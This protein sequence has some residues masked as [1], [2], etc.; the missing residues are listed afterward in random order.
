MLIIR[1][2]YFVDALTEDVDF[3]QGDILVDGGKIKAITPCGTIKA[4]VIEEMDIQG[5]TLLPGLIDMHVH[6]M[7][8][9]FDVNK[10]LCTTPAEYAVQCME[11]ANV[12]LN[13]GYT[14]VRD[15]G[16]NPNS[17]N[18]LALSTAFA[19]DRLQGPTVVPSGPILAPTSLGTTPA[20]CEYFDGADEVRKRVRTTLRKGAKFIKMYGSGSMT[21]PGKHTGFPIIDEDEVREAVKVAKSYDTYV[22]VHAHG[23]EVIDMLARAGVRTIE[24]ASLISEETLLYMEEHREDVGIVPTLFVF[25]NSFTPNPSVVQEVAD[26]LSKLKDNVISCLKNAYRHDVQIGWG[27]DVT[28]GDYKAHPESEFKLR[29]EWL[30]CKDEDI[31]C[32]ATINSAKLMRMDDRIG[33]IKV[34]KDADFIVVNGDP[35]EDITVMYNKPLH[36]IKK[37]VVIR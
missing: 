18:T 37:G 2:C 23:E 31:I 21:T 15:V 35:S 36:V 8:A 3:S 34:G 26:H 12:L 27:T 22:A 7:C 28:I 33:S 17:L 9:N 1:N 11:Y 20:I 13:L 24:H 19:T 25:S 10:W 16:D 32:Q 4:D 6:L 14:T 29:K 5:K 30:E